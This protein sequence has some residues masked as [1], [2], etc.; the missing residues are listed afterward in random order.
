MDHTLTVT[1]LKLRLL[2][3]VTRYSRALVTI[4]F[5]RLSKAIPNPRF[6][7]N[8]EANFY[9]SS[10]E[11]INKTSEKVLSLIFRLTS[12]CTC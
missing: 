1:L 11:L 2:E 4:N 7:K 10:L 5:G 6:I 12:K 8:K 3:S 9:K